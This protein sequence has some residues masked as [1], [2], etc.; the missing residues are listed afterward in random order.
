MAYSRCQFHFD[1]KFHA[2]R[3]QNLVMAFSSEKKKKHTQRA[4]KMFGFGYGFG[5]RS[6]WN[7]QKVYKSN[8]WRNEPLG[9][10][11]ASDLLRVAA[12]G[13][14]APHKNPFLIVEM[15]VF[16]YLLFQKN[17]VLS[18]LFDFFN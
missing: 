12:S 11:F 15:D 6:I 1:K 7:N 16:I 3:I 2:Y 9:W 8:D 10:R 4:N 18:L 14:H 13:T 17:S 5:H